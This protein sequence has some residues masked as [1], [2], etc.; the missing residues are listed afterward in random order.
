MTF[1]R[2]VVGVSVVAYGGVGAFFLLA[3]ELAAAQVDLG[4]GS[5]T[6]DN[7][8]RAVYGGLQL[9][10]AA[11]LCIALRREAWLS[12]ALALLGVTMGG[13]ALARLVSWAAVGLPSGLAL[14]LHAAE[15]AGVAAAALAWRGLERPAGSA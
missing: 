15:V 5:A 8:V 3:P 10:V 12:P 4:L 2:L 13:L 11:F 7:D 9:G 6:A 1:A 14:A